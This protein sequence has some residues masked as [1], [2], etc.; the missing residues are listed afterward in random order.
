M[1]LILLKNYRKSQSLKPQFDEIVN[2]TLG[3]DL[4]PALQVLLMVKLVAHFVRLIAR[5]PRRE[6][7]H[8]NELQELIVTES[9]KKWK[10]KR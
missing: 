8:I 4:S 9:E 1:N 2:K 6:D 7:K 10:L 5:H 3:Y